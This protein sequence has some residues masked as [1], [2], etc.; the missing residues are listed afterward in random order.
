MRQ[1]AIS[2]LAAPTMQIKGLIGFTR[3]PL[4]ERCEKNQ[5]FWLELV[6]LRVGI[7]GLRVELV[8]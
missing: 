5:V 6:A 8:A 1:V 2:N 7:L 4:A 3:N